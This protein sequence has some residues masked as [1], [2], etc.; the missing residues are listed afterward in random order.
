MGDGFLIAGLISLLAALSAGPVAPEILHLARIQSNAKAGLSGIPAYTC[1]ETMER[2]TRDTARGQFHRND[3]LKLEVAEIG[4]KELFS[5]AGE[6]T[7]SEDGL[8]QYAARGLI[9]T[10]MF[11]HMAET[12]FGT[13]VAR[14]EYAGAKRVKG[15]RALQ[16]NL[17]VSELFA[18]YR[19]QFNYHE[20]QC[21]LKG[22]IWADEST[23]D[24]L[25]MHLEATDIP[26]ELLLKS[27]VTEIDYTRAAMD[28]KS[29]LIPS[30]AEIVTEFLNGSG[31]RNQIRFSN[32]HKYGVESTLIFQ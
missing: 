22:S 1:S 13:P 30:S 25:R 4:G 18:N 27:A 11:Y 5:K 23:F 14:F 21:G 28:G 26:P 12:V 10:G 7:F 3:E 8:Q 19:L 29:Y 16:Y 2:S 31:S 24:L 9:A 15:R 20:A 32:C 6:K 17:T